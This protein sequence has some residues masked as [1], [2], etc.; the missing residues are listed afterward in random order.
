MSD[1]VNNKFPHLT[2]IQAAKAEA[3][4]DKI[5]A[6][7][8]VRQLSK[9]ADWTILQDITQ[10]IIAE[11]T[12]ENPNVKATIT[13]VRQEL[14]KQI[15]ERYKNDP[16]TKKI[17]IDGTPSLDAIQAWVK[18]EGW[19]EAVWRKIHATGLFSKER[20]AAMIDALYK[21]GIERD[22]VAA[23]IWLT[24]SGDYVE[25]SQI[26]N[27]D[28]TIERFREVNNILHKNKKEG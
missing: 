9:G 4:G 6:V 26:D 12:V 17:L 23:K 27:K 24:L 13:E 15:E 7:A 21:R 2:P 22:T 14:L 8:K 18:K 25:K 1:D 11:K 28:S 3:A 5:R 20:R 10:D 16:E 19:D